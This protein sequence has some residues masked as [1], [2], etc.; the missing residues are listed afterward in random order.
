MK[1]PHRNRAKLDEIPLIEIP[2]F[3]NIT[4]SLL[5]GQ[6]FISNLRFNSVLVFFQF[7]GWKVE[8]IYFPVMTVHLFMT[9]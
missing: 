9:A 2:P 5:N 8:K 6:K 1:C 7:L 4:H 3:R